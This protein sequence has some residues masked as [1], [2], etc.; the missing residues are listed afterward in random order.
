MDTR[1]EAKLR[2]D[3]RVS[4]R[5]LAAAGVAAAAG[6]DAHALTHCTDTIFTNGFDGGA[7]SPV[8][9]HRGASGPSAVLTD[10]FEL[11]AL[12]VQLP[13]SLTAIGH[14]NGEVFLLAFADGNFDRVFGLE[15]GLGA[16]PAM[17]ASIRTSD[18][19]ITPI[20]ITPTPTGEWSG[21]KQ[22]PLSGML[23]AVATTCGSSSILYTIDRSTAAFQRIGEIVGVPCAVSLAIGP[24]GDM[25]SMDVGL[26]ELFEIDQN[27]ADASSVGSIGF[28]AGYQ[29]MDFDGAT[30]T[31]YAA[32]LNN[33]THRNE[34]RAIDRLTGESA[35]VGVI[36]VDQTVGFAI[37]NAV[38]CTP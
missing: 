36:P 31:L 20:G 29:D 35:L 32:G 38:V 27:N 14:T 3:L 12:D 19:A 11:Y 17:L 24:H 30:G 26:D 4:L 33:S 37:E 21:F 2:S 16:H 22:D 8:A 5:I 15:P 28:D 34:L 6:V 10:G 13:A 25:Y 23:Y 7:R 9:M 18:A 1:R